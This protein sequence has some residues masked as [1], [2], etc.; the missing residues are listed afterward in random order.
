MRTGGRW[1]YEVR[2]PKNADWFDR[3]PE[4]IATDLRTWI[5]RGYLLTPPAQADR[6]KAH[7]PM[8]A[9]AAAPE[10]SAS[11]SFGAPK[12]YFVINEY[13]FSILYGCSSAILRI[14]GRRFQVVS[15]RLPRAR[16]DQPGRPRMSRQC[17]GV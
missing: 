6:Y 13:N 3:H 17:S 16:A 1:A 5:R 2:A 12:N 14:R 4:V 11:P 10:G 15:K 8:P 7:W 9:S